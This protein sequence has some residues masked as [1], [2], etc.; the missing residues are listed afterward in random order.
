MKN[1]RK[2]KSCSK[3]VVGGDLTSVD[4]FYQ[5]PLPSGFWLDSTSGR[6]QP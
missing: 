2:E 4:C 1:V 3:Y 6:Y 5:V